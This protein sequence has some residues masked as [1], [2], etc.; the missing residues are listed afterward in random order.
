VKAK[1]SGDSNESSEANLEPDVEAEPLGDSDT[2]Y[3]DG[4]TDEDD[5][6]KGPTIND[7]DCI[8]Y[9]VEIWSSPPPV[10]KDDLK[11]Q[12]KK[13][14]ELMKRN[15]GNVD[16]TDKRTAMSTG[17]MY[18]NHRDPVKINFTTPTKVWMR[19]ANGIKVRRYNTWSRTRSRTLFSF[20]KLPKHAVFGVTTLEHHGPAWSCLSRSYLHQRLIPII[21]WDLTTCPLCESG[22]N[23]GNSIVHD[24]AIE[25][26]YPRVNYTTI[27][28]PAIWKESKKK[29]KDGKSGIS[30][31]PKPA[32]RASKKPK[33]GALQKGL[34]K[35]ADGIQTKEDVWR[36]EMRTAADEARL[37]ALDFMKKKGLEDQF[38][39]QEQ[40]VV[41]AG[42]PDILRY[43]FYKNLYRALEAQSSIGIFDGS[44]AF[45]EDGV[46][47]NWVPGLYESTA[48]EGVP[49][50]VC[51]KTPVEAKFSGKEYDIPNMP[52]EPVHP[53]HTRTGIVIS[54]AAAPD[55]DFDTGSFA[56]DERD[57]SFGIS[58]PQ[59]M[60]AQKRRHARSSMSPLKPLSKKCMHAL[61]EDTDSNMF[62]SSNE[63]YPPHESGLA[64]PSNTI[65]SR[66]QGSPTTETGHNTEGI[67][68]AHGDNSGA[69]SD[70]SCEDEELDDCV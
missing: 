40:E 61:S 5:R 15:G 23:R 58:P 31:T 20:M 14:D 12:T 42:Y 18:K 39:W 66:F 10:P 4:N 38:R 2:N 16:W 62:D 45:V 35:V 68:T 3:H 24:F 22:R 30:A 25:T 9:K 7:N 52:E 55:V 26:Y 64:M 57:D 11:N 43:Q 6:N 32:S 36:L 53:G 21:I 63:G 1:V 70:D 46:W 8:P 51:K 56:D 27:K 48:I 33:A 44:R 29:D 60:E 13:G 69:P 47:V 28:W 17:M 50:L 49:V 67:Q 37:V 59:L 54:S 41:N 34:K 65:L 19:R